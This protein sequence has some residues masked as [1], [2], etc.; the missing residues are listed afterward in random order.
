[1]SNINTKTDKQFLLFPT[2]IYKEYN[3]ANCKYI[4]CL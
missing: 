2:W 4:L 3:H 1:M